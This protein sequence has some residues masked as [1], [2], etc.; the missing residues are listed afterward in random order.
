MRQAGR[1]LPEYR[2][3]RAKAGSFLNL[4]FSPEDAAEVTLQPLRRYD[5]DAAILFADILLIPMFTGQKLSFE[6]G[7]GPRLR[8]ALQ[9]EPSLELSDQGVREELQPIMETV[10][11]VRAE[12]SEDK[13]FIGFAGAPWTVATY[14]IAGQGQ[15]DPAALRQFAYDEPDAFK[16]L[17]ELLEK[18]TITYLSDQIEAGV[19]VVQLFETWAA[20]LPPDFM[21]AYCLE[22]CK[23]IASELKK[24]HPETPIIVFP[25]GAGSLLKEYAVEK[26]FDG[27]GLDT[28]VD[29]VWARDELAADIALQGGLDPLLVVHGG[30]EMRQAA[31]KLKETYADARYIFNLGHG[32]VPQTPPENV[33]ELMRIIRE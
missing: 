8:P 25:R 32:F 7:E 33:S 23:R 26:A 27:L 31:L 1:Y 19:Q 28:S 5:L 22:P 17:M 15:K 9:E 29:P 6:A 18:T 11:R 13:C 2:E 20:G 30:A 14:M 21:R 4:C 3:T 12:L 16:R 10:R 24:K